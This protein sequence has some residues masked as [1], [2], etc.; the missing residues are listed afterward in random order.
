MK[1]ELNKNTVL[2]V[3]PGTRPPELAWH[4]F[5]VSNSTGMVEHYIN[6]ELRAT[7]STENFAEYNASQ[8]NYDGITVA[9]LDTISVPGG[10]EA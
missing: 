4:R 10:L 5:N 6:E 2:G 7:I 1:I 8:L 9:E 3:L